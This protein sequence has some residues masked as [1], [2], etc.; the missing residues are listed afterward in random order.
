MFCSLAIRTRQCFQKTVC[1][2]FAVSPVMTAPIRAPSLQRLVSDA[3]EAKNPAANAVAPRIIFEEPSRDEYFEGPGMFPAEI[4]T[5]LS[6]RSAPARRPYRTPRTQPVARQLCLQR[7]FWKK[8]VVGYREAPRGAN[9][10][11]SLSRP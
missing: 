11:D 9:T 3:Q 6:D 10:P 2:G 4:D 1:L 8:G 5:R 7:D